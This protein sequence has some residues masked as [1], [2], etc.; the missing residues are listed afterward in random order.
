MYHARRDTSA[1][2]CECE[3]VSKRE[4]R[5]RVREGEREKREKREEKSKNKKGVF[6]FE[7]AFTT[8]IRQCRAASFSHGL[9]A[10]N[11]IAPNAQASLPSFPL[12]LRNDNAN[13]DHR[14]DVK[15]TVICHRLAKQCALRC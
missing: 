5:E 9:D 8:L 13:G 3:R 2:A 6:F 11:S 10:P 12:A 1:R 15:I 4:K 14:F 7:L